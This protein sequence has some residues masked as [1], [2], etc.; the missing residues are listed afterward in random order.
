MHVKCNTE[1]LLCNDF[2][3]RKTVRIKYYGYVSVFLPYLK[4]VKTPSFLR[5]IVLSSVAYLNAQYFS[6]LSH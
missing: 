2:C 1:A 6:T 5:R 4:F 3:R